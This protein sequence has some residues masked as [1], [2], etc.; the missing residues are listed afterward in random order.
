[1]HVK[2]AFC[3]ERLADINIPG[4]R[5]RPRAR[6]INLWKFT[7]RCLTAARRTNQIVSTRGGV[8]NAAFCQVVACRACYGEHRNLR[9]EVLQLFCDS[10]GYFNMRNTCCIHYSEHSVVQL[11]KRRYVTPTAGV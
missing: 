8:S 2:Y 10:F 4:L 11:H 5:T 1:M 9:A 3:V 6:K 7:Y